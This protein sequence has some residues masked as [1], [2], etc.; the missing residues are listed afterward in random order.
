MPGFLSRTFSWWHQAT[1]GARRDAASGRQVGEDEYGNRYFLS[2]NGRKRFV[3][4]P[5]IVDASL[6]PPDWH[7]WLHGRDMPPPSERALVGP[8]WIKPHVPN[9]TGT[10]LAHAPSGSMAKSG[11]RAKA[12]GDYEAWSPQ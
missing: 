3:L 5:G 4:Y 11:V 7:L 8:S 2:K 6:I 1:F 9:L 12:T 10:P